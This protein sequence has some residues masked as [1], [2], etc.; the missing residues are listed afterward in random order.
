MILCH[1]AGINNKLKN[2]FINEVVNVSENIMIL[3]LD[4]IS[5]QIIYDPDYTKIYNQFISFNQFNNNIQNKGQ[6]LSQLSQIWKYKFTNTVNDLLK[7]HEAK[8]IILIG[9]ITFYLDYR[10]RVIL[11]EEIKNKFFI[12]TS[13]IE[14]VKQQIEYNLDLYKNDIILGKFPLKY[15]DHDFL[16]NQREELREQYMIK[17]Y[18][19]KNYDTIINWITHFVKGL[20]GGGLGKPVYYASFKRYENN[21]EML[22]DTIVGYSDKWLAL[23]SMFPKTKFKRGVTFKGGAKTPYI[24]EMGPMNFKD[25]NTCCYVYELYPSKKVD[26]H[27]YLIENNNFIQRHYVSNIKNDLELDGSILEKFNY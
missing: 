1:I 18:K 16:K 2:N 20:S 12:N 23:I 14:H 5:K 10:I 25:L 24:K 17:D 3:D 22:S 27:R 11:N 6:I 4:D 26:E 8:Q 13:T 9:Q 21:I 15:L 19:L 7:Q